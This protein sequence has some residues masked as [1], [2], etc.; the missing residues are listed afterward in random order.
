MPTHV[1]EGIDYGSGSGA[2]SG[3]RI[4]KDGDPATE[5][6]AVDANALWHGL[7]TLVKQEQISGDLTAADGAT[8]QT[9]GYIRLAKALR[10]ASR[11]VQSAE[12]TTLVMDSAGYTFTPTKD[13]FVYLIT[14]DGGGPYLDG[15]VYPL[16]SVPTT[17]NGR[18]ILVINT[19]TTQK[20]VGDSGSQQAATLR[21]NEACLF[22]G[23][24]V[25]GPATK[26]VPVGLPLDVA[27]FSYPTVSVKYYDDGD[28]SV[29]SS[30]VS[31]RPVFHGPGGRVVTINI[32]YASV[33]MGTTSTG[34]TLAPA[35]GFADM[36]DTYVAFDGQDGSSVISP[37]FL[38]L[39]DIGGTFQVFRAVWQGN[40]LIIR[41]LDGT[42]FGAAAVVGIYALSLTYLVNR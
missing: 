4:F 34:I 19:S 31:M 8:D 33:T 7:R 42:A 36:P 20:V 9:E 5:V 22:F 21:K 26:W 23:L 12:V 10:R 30:A 40:N 38:V 13:G 39:G 35:A 6:I 14:E 2:L 29:V 28:H 24:A 32:P 27:A 15:A 3:E 16:T 41:K 11:R 17:H 18:Y 37:Q 25:S 1:L